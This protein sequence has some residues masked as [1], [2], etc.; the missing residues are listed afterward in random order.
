MVTM[1]WDHTGGGIEVLGQHVREFTG[2]I[3][4]VATDGLDSNTGL[5]PT[6]P[7][8]TIGSAV[9]ASSDGDAITVKAGTY[10]ESG[11]DVNLAG[12]KLWLEGGVIL[13]DTAGGTVI[14]VSGS[15]CQV[16]GNA[17][18]HPTAAVGMSL[19]GGRF[20]V[21]DIQVL[22]A[23]TGFDAQASGGIF[24][25][26]GAG[27]P[28]V[29]GF[30]FIGSKTWVDG[31]RTAGTGGA[32][33]G[34]WLK[35]S[36][37]RMWSCESTGH[38]T[39]G[40]QA[41]AGSTYCM[42]RDCASGAG[43]GDRIDNGSNNMWAGFV[44]R[45]QSEHHEHLY[46]VSDG[47]GTAGGPVTVSNSTTDDSGGTTDDQDYWGDPVRI[48]PPSVITEMWSSVGLYINA[49][50]TADDQQWQVFFPQSIYSS[51]QNGGND[52]DKDETALTVADGTVFQADDLVWITG[53]DVP[54]GE[55]LKVVSSVANVVT[56]VSETRTGGGVGVRYDYDI[57]PGNNAM[58]VVSRDDDRV[59]H[60]FDGAYSAGSAKD[61]SRFVWH[62]AKQINANGG[63]IM[64]MLNASDAL[65]SSLGARAIYED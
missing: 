57:A 44:D 29:T 60:G 36:Y 19:T 26:C 5:S 2:T 14:T 51:A 40:Y 62:E 9:A 27:T 25:R 48:I 33:K 58:Y 4:Y 8:L 16:I 56:V 3:R 55:I 37:V 35:G 65:G 52:W 13:R 11:L 63:M 43:D 34:F 64:R 28:S 42:V 7:K 61:F 20:L 54:N 46:P 59:L 38:G 15:D 39:A 31:C 45:M 1:S 47:E 23:T 22:S 21:E 17:I 30:D 12:L 49:I 6:S 53:D 50:T 24:R 18:I 32:T 41:D 10:D